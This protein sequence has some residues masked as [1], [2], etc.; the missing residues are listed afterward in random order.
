MVTT[1]I[2][3]NTI[4]TAILVGKVNP[5]FGVGGAAPH[6][7]KSL[8]HKGLRQSKKSFKI[9]LTVTKG[10]TM[11]CDNRYREV[12]NGTGNRDSIR[13]GLGRSFLDYFFRKSN[14]PLTNAKKTV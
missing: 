13:N 1:G 7:R 2:M 12:N 5:T 9:M 11:L 4:S 3:A 8:C 14:N 10:V 6:C